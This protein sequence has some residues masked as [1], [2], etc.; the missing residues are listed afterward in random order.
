MPRPCKMIVSLPPS[1]IDM[2]G[3]SRQ[4][5]ARTS[6]IP[7]KAGVQA[8][9]GDGNKD[10]RRPAPYDDSWKETNPRGFPAISFTADERKLMNI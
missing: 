6:V 5:L 7:A 4:D 9:Q 8:G 10:G 1:K 3:R 2:E